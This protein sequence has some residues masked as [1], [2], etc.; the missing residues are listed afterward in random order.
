M[1]EAITAAFIAAGGSVLL[2]TAGL[3]VTWGM[4]RQMVKAHEQRIEKA[5]AR[6]E[7]LQDE[8]RQTPVLAHAIEAMGDK[9]S[10]AIQGLAER[11]GDHQSHMQRQL[12]EIRGDLRGRRA[13]R[14]VTP[15]SE[16]D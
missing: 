12:D 11:F 3:C 7:K 8:G 4:V 6:I 9:F 2:G 16:G 10:L 1:S 13:P 15:P 14:L 5:E